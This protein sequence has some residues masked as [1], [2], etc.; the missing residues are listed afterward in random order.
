MTI[1]FGRIPAT[2]HTAAGPDPTTR[3]TPRMGALSHNNVSNYFHARLLKCLSFLNYLNQPEKQNTS[4]TKAT[5]EILYNPIPAEPAGCTSYEEQA[6][7][8]GCSSQRHEAS[9]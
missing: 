5:S 6:R 2:I 9:A 7:T 3:R 1:V 4:A 8:N